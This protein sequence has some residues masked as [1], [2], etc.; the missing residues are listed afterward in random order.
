MPETIRVFRTPEIQERFFAAY[1]ALL[2]RWP[3][4]Y[5]ECF[6]PTRFGETHV[7]ASGAEHAAPLVLLHPGGSC[8]LSWY[9]N[10]GRLSHFYRVYAVDVIGEVNKSRPTRK[11]RSEAEFASWIEDL[12]DGLAID[13]ADLVGN[14][15]GG[16]LALNAALLLP[17]RV[18]KLALISPAATF[19]EMPA[20]YLH[21]LIPAH[22]IAPLARSERMVLN[23]YAWLWNGF[24]MEESYAR[25]HALAKTA[26][27]PQYRPTQNTVR[28]RVFRDDELRQLRVPTL[29]LIGDHEVIYPPERA[30]ERATRLAPGL[31]SAIV[32]NANHCAHMT[33]PEAVNDKMIEF[34]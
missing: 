30:I 24:P 3:V 15:Y 1:D 31:Q 19:V 27:F 26:G 32:P 25:L 21:L 22:M 10:V 20:W 16:F 7:V 2:R 23:A 9:R 33:A 14:S 28:P 34:L 6:I 5:E 13:R 4:P 29:L 8:A 18:R 11:I 17:E 12:F